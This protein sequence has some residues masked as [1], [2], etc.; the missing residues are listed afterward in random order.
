LLPRPIRTLVAILATLGLVAAISAIPAAAATCAAAASTANEVVTDDVSLSFDGEFTCT[1]ADDPGT[2]SITVNVTNDS[3]AEVTISTVELSQVTPSLQ[4]DAAAAAAAVT[5][6]TLPL[7]LAAGAAG[8]FDVAGDY[9]LAQVGAGSLLNV[10]LRASG[11]AAGD[12]FALGVNVHLLGPGVQ[13]DEAQAEADA[14]AQVQAQGGAAIAIE[15]RQDGQPDWLPG[16]PPWVLELIASL[17][18]D[19][20]AWGTPD[21]AAA[22]GGE[23]GAG[24]SAG[25]T[26]S[27][28][29]AAAGGAAAGAGSA[30]EAGRPS[31]VERP[32]QGAASGTA[33]AEVGAS[34]D[35]DAGA[36]VE[37]SAGASGQ[38]IVAPLGGRP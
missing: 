34:A 15:R 17:H 5:S 32:T 26:A 14:E 3:D 13:L 27:D 31:S 2:W 30:A 36:T 20:L 12:P 37:I 23:A 22:W 24:G 38:V 25:A 7:T 35:A 29:A 16:P 4:A 18:P 11:T 6:D 1:D 21:F 9:T 28:G 8:F 19:G 10:H 33:G